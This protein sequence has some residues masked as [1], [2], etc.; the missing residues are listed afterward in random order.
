MPNML[1]ETDFEQAATFLK[2]N[3]AAIKAVAEIGSSGNGFLSSSWK[4]NGPRA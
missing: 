1:T 3:V 4:E 2:C